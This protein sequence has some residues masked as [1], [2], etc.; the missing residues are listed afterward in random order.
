MLAFRE[1]CSFRV[2]EEG[3]EVCF[4]GAGG[5]EFYGNAATGTGDAGVG[6]QHGAPGA[7]LEDQTDE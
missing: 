5:G 4:L 7:V 2:A 3:V 1:F 6:D